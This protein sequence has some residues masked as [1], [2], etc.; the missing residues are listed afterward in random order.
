M[1]P[2]A[3]WLLAIV[4]LSLVLRALLFAGVWDPDDYMYAKVA[5]DVRVGLYEPADW[6]ALRPSVFLPVAASFALFGVGDLSA[7][8]WPIL[9]STLALVAFFVLLRRLESP[10]VALL[11]C[12]LLA[13]S[14]GFLF[15]GSALR[16][17]AI[18]LLA[19]V[20]AAAALVEADVRSATRERL[21][22]LAACAGFAFLGHLARLST[23]PLFGVFV[24]AYWALRGRFRPDWL[25]VPAL[26]LVGLFA[27][28]LWAHAAAGDPLARLNLL[29]DYFRDRTYALRPGWYA[30]P[31]AIDLLRVRGEPAGV[32]LALPLLAIVAAGVLR[33]RRLPWMLLA[34]GVGWWLYLE[35]GSTSLS[36]FQPPFKE[37]RY[38]L[39]LLL[40]ACATLAWCLDA[41]FR[42]RGDGSAAG[43]R[44][45]RGVAVA[46]GLALLAGGAAFAIRPVPRPVLKHVAS[47]PALVREAL[48]PFERAAS[49]LRVAPGTVYLSPGREPRRWARAVAFHLGYPAGGPEDARAVVPGSPFVVLPRAASFQAVERGYVLRL[50]RPGAPAPQRPD[51]LLVSREP[52]PGYRF[53]LYRVG[54]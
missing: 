52:G 51:W 13:T 45:W 2:E 8:A 10:H 43:S 3:A 23:L 6:Y 21:P 5:N 50:E 32:W 4:G 38:L 42:G 41:T 53:A 40:P 44:A 54:R 29:Q 46:A 24:L 1:L 20:A 48:V 34:W 22:W 35:F 14:P 18:V 9:A 16:P 30:A 7:C 36:R 26:L 15:R 28:A 37:G 25:L 12:A 27:E 19:W 33:A 11:A 39:P 17:D 49:L 31:T 47:D